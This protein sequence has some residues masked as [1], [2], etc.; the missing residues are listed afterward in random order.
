M[1][2]IAK[3]NLLLELDDLLDLLVG[4]SSLSG[5]QLLAFFGALVEE[6]R[7]DLTIVMS[8]TLFLILFL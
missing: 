3:K 4:E 7:I 8:K 2:E 6:A 1:I 5:H